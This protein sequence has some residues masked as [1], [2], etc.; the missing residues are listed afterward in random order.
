MANIARVRVTLTGFIGGPGVSTFYALDGAALIAP[1]RAFYD[2]WRN[3]FPADVRTQVESAGDMIDPATGALTGSWVGTPVSPSSGSSGAVYAA[4]V[5]LLVK[6]LTA[7]VA[8]RSRVK[9]R[10]FMVPI[11]NTDFGSDGQPSP[12]ALDARRLD[13]AA[14]VTAASPNLVVW[15]RPFAGSPSVGNRPARPAHAGSVAIVV[16][17]DISAKAAV[18][19]SRRD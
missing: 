18:L 12:A 9:G 4:P 5:G 19:R 13:A 1:L 10:T 2:A 14:F 16:G 6:W 11:V 3:D 17:S 8:D 7:T 15:H